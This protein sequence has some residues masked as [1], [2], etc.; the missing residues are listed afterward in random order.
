MTPPSHTLKAL[1]A[2]RTKWFAFL[3]NIQTLREHLHKE[4]PGHEGL[5]PYR[6]HE[7]GDGSLRFDTE[8]EAEYPW[9]LCQAYARAL[10]QQIDRDDGTFEDM[11]LQE[12][13]RYYRDQLGQSTNRLSAE[14]VAAP[15]AALLAR[16]EMTMVIGQERTHLR[17][18][19]RAASYR[20]TD[21]R[22]VGELGDDSAMHVHEVPYLAMRW[23][24]KTILAFPWKQP[25]HINELELNTVAVFLK[26]RARSSTKHRAK[27]FLVLDSAVTRGCVSKGRSSSRRLNQVVRRC[28]AHLLGTDGYLFPL[29]ISA[30]NC[31]DKP[32]RM[33]EAQA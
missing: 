24:W 12:R 8:E 16:V 28:T 22:L 4:C 21:V 10:Q 13:E 29:W 5:Q 25:A 26:R 2:A 11:V 15:I 33:H 23:Q 27:F 6:V 3:G 19:L 17:S 30:W 31:A 7:Q 20:G 18:L 9:P 32:N 14:I 1:L